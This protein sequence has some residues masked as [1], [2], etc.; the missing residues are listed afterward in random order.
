MLLCRLSFRE[1][2]A[3]LGTCWFVSF[4]FLV[5]AIGFAAASVD[6]YGIGKKRDFLQIS[7]ATPTSQAIIGDPNG[8]YHFSADLSGA[9]LNQISPVPQITLPST[10]QFTLSGNSA[11]MGIASNYTNKSALDAAFPNGAYSITVGTTV[12]PVTFGAGD[13]YP[14]E[15]PQITNGTWDGEGRLVINASA[16]ST[17]NFNEF[18]QYLTGVGGVISFTLHTV[19]GTTL[20]SELATVERVSLSGYGSD[21]ALSSYTIP[22]GLLQAN[23]IYYAELS[24]A[25]IAN[26]NTTFL[27][28]VGSATFLHTTGLMIST[29]VPAVAPVITT[30]PAGQTII[31]GANVVLS[32]VA[33]GSPAPTY[34][35][36]KDGV[37]IA[38]ATL[39]TFSLGNTQFSDAGSYSVVASNSAGLVT[40]ETAV[41][42]VNPVPVAVSFSL[43]PV[44]QSVIAGGSVTFTTA[45]S[46]VPAPSLQWA[47]GGVPLSGATT[48]SFTIASAQLSDAG[49]YT[50]VA[51]NSVNSVTSNSVVLAVNLAPFFTTQPL[52]QTI[53]IGNDVTFTTEANGIPSPTFQW[54]RNGVNIS[55]AT[56]ASYTKA[57]VGVDDAASYTVLATNTVGSVAS[58]A[59]VLSVTSTVAPSSAT[60]SFTVE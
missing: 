5:P 12:M 9:N 11:S 1:F 60:I 41:L 45:V 4:C 36:R 15:T 8:P 26:L 46:G 42:T 39:A 24:F 27:P 29:T 6:S 13:S 35:W 30:Q 2:F 23:R 20:G 53:T 17:L 3:S 48:A 47:K 31:V 25:R 49:T 10:S 44:G 40:S 59:A 37:A 51:T 57:G 55:G 38:G 33:S 14:A 54:Q 19:S 58:N 21:A 50:V 56:G 52:S 32:V 34:Q 43:Q 7:A 22:V 28:I 16:E 18:S